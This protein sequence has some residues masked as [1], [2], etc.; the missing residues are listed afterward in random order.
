MFHTTEDRD[1]IINTLPVEQWNLIKDEVKVEDD[2]ILYHDEQKKWYDGSLGYPD[3]DAH[4]ALIEAAKN[5]QYEHEY[6]EGADGVEEPRPGV[7]NLGIFIRLGE[8]DDDTEKD[9]WGIED[10]GFPNWYD[11]VD[12]RRE[13]VIGWAE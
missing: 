1:K 7:P 11:L 5:A 9:N 3:V 4:I 10:E 2:R 8:D 6:Y 13:I 12:Y